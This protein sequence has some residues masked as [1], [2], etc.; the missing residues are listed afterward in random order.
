VLDAWAADKSAIQTYQSG[1]DGPDAADALM[2]EDDD[3]T[4]RP[5][6]LPA[7]QKP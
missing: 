2:A 1:S 5:V 7:E 6:E 3:R 4:W